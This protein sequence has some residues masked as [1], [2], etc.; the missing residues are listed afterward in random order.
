MV[1]SSLSPWSRVKAE[2]EHAWVARCWGAS[3]EARARRIRR[4][5]LCFVNEGE[6]EESEKICVSSCDF[7][8]FFLFSFFFFSR[9][10]SEKDIQAD[11]GKKAV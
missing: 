9:E 10:K 8:L 2:E 4:L 7:Y 6:R 3:L 1:Q 11:W 5:R